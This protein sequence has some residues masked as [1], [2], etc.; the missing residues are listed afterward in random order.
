MT[1]CGSSSTTRT[2]AEGLHALQIRECPDG[3]N[4]SWQSWKRVHCWAWTDEGGEDSL[5][6]ALRTHLTQSSHHRSLG[7]EDIDGLVS[8]ASIDFG[9][10]YKVPGKKPPTE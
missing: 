10:K 6:E 1:H 4:C 8:G 7:P 5:R 3:E 2:L 9:K